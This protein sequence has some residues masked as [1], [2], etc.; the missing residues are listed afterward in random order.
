[1]QYKKW[2]ANATHNAE[3]FLKAVPRKAQPNLGNMKKQT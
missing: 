1:M 3:Q 2:A